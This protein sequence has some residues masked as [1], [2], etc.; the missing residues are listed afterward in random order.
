MSD[1]PAAF[2]DT[3]ALEAFSPERLR[4]ERSAVQLWTLVRDFR[5]VSPKWGTITAQAGMVTDFA[6]VPTFAKR[7]VDDDSPMILYPSI[8]HDWLYHCGGLQP[9][10]RSF[11]RLEADQVLRDAMRDVGAPGHLAALVF[12][13]VRVGGGRP[14]RRA[15]NNLAE[16][17]R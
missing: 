14:W 15:I 16:A 5:Y 13:A 11:S 9:E 6:S 3:L 12:S 7:I 1:E 10:G 17:Q 2:P 8:I 4:V